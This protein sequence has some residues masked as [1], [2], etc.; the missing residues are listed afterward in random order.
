MLSY[1]VVI[2]GAGPAGITAG[3]LLQKNGL[4]CCILERNNTLRSKACA[5]GTTTK[6]RKLCCEIYGD[7]F[8]RDMETVTTYA[9]NLGDDYIHCSC[10]LKTPIV[11]ID[12]VDLNKWML[13][14]F[15]D[16]GGTVYYSQTLCNLDTSE[17]IVYSQ[18]GAWKYKYL[19]GADGINS[20]V[21]HVLY[22]D[23]ISTRGYV[24]YKDIEPIICRDVISIR[25][26]MGHP[27]YVWPRPNYIQLA[28]WT[29]KPRSKA[30]PINTGGLPFLQKYEHELLIGAAGMLENP[31][32]GEGIYT[33]ISS[34]KHAYQHIVEG[35]DYRRWIKKQMF[36]YK[37]YQLC[38]KL[39]STKLCHYC[40]KSPMLCKLVFD[41]EINRGLLR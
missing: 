41:F 3:Y 20:R 30:A 8:T 7:D 9:L 17:K 24:E 11:S 35:K 39:S 37:A 1:D 15:L 4:S 10:Q 33:A 13:S 32:T 40:L 21:R 29:D 25:M 36:W 28:Q 5:G 22:G 14:H 27:Q 23:V 34:A 31:A 16:A 19:V 26:H 18:T 12:R 38:W 6:M 2:I